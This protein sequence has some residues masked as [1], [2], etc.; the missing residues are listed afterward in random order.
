MPSRTEAGVGGGSRSGPRGE[1]LKLSSA[2]L[3]W[4]TGPA[5]SAGPA[6]LQRCPGRDQDLSPG[7]PQ[8]DCF[9]GIQTEVL[10]T[11]TW[12]LCVL[13]LI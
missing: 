12:V 5:P 8:P 1:A 9:P 10:L 13:K 2:R 4:K 11:F 7:I 6:S 3:G